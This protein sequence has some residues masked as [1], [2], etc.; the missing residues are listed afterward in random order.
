MRR[1]A[2]VTIVAVMLI[3][4]AVASLV[5]LAVL[6]G[7]LAVGHHPHPP[8]NP[9][10]ALAQ[11]ACRIPIGL[12]SAIGL[13]S[14]LLDGVAG[15]LL[16]RRHESGRTL[17]AAVGGCSLLV[18]IATVRLYVFA[19]V[20]AAFYAVFMLLLFRPV[21]TRWLRLERA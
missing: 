1:P 5:S 10:A 13:G 6:F 17:Y 9:A 2:G 12:S 8:D 19:I 3:L 7:L 11:S 14:G 20:P 21:A 16:L 4:G 15:I 18:G